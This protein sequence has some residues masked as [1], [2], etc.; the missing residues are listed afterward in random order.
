MRQKFFFL[1]VASIFIITFVPVIVLIGD[2]LYS[3]PKE[4][5]LLLDISV[6]KV[7]VKSFFLSILVAFSTTVVGTMLGILF[8]KSDLKFTK[9]FL[10]I[11]IIPLLIPPFMIAYGWF[12]VLGRNSLLFG[13]LGVW[14]V[15]FSIFLPIPLLFSMLALKEIDISL[16]EASLIFTS[17]KETLK[18][19]TLPLIFPSLIFSFLIVFILSFGEYSVANYLRYDTFSLQS[20]VYFSAFYDYQKATLLSLPTV[21]VVLL[22]MLYFEVLHNRYTFGINKTYKIK[23]IPI[24]KYKKMITLMLVF[25]VFVVDVVPIF[26]LLFKGLD[27]TNFIDGLKLGYKPL[28]KS[29]IYSSL[30]ASILSIFGFLSAYIIVEKLFKWYKLYDKGLLFLFVLPPTVFAISFTL[31]Y[32]HTWSDIIYASPLII[33]FA[34]LGK[35][36]FLSTKVLQSTLEKIPASFIETAKLSG[37][38]W[39]EIIYFILLPLSKNALF[40][41]WIIGF[42][43]SFREISMTMILYPPGYQTLPIEII[44]QMANGQESVIASM[45]SIMIVISSLMLGIVFKLSRTKE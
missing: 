10:F 42:I 38:S 41:A 13:F 33:L 29:L 22:V 40:I 12:E 21:G 6:W 7:F 31:F 17:P 35:F 26:M 1:V 14:F 9:F 27:F 2:T 28:L 36:L 44:T 11:L 37:A 32:N 45:S 25:F 15:H 8:V 24:Q 34:Y 23:K 19:I 43:F 4:Y 5:S 3:L 18:S 39:K 30:S 20:F 16:E